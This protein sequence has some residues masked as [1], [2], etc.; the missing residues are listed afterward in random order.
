MLPGGDPQFYGLLFVLLGL[1]A[2][3]LA[4]FANAKHIAIGA[5][6]IVISRAFRTETVP[7]SDIVGYWRG[8][9]R[10]RL[11]TTTSQGLIKFMP[12]LLDDPRVAPFFAGLVNLDAAAENDPALGPTLEARRKRLRGLR[13]RQVTLNSVVLVMMAVFFAAM[14]AGSRDS[15]FWQIV[16]A[17]WVA[18]AAAVPL[19]AIAIS[20]LHRKLPVFGLCSPVEGTDIFFLVL[21]PGSA[22]LLAAMADV[23]LFDL[24]KALIA[25]AT[26]GIALALVTLLADPRTRRI[27][28]FG[29]L[30]V[31]FAIW[32]YGLLVESNSVFDPGPGETYQAQVETK[33]RSDNMYYVNVGPW[34]PMKNGAELSVYEDDYKTVRAGGT[35]TVYLCHGRFGLRYYDIAPCN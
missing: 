16:I 29:A 17:G 8:L 9:Y 10:I 4:F 27:K 35:V 25:A 20:A 13:W 31:L 11:E 26:I 5:D 15:V 30:A 19:I 3:M 28:A 32:G 1:Y 14:I 34:G 22:L 12:A 24:D 23:N 18:M 21:G 2:G 6:R 7:Q 33:H